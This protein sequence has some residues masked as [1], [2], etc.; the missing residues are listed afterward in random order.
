MI[1]IFALGQ[2]LKTDR[3]LHI[4][5]PFNSHT[6]QQLLIFQT[7]TWRWHFDKFAKD[8]PNYLWVQYMKKYTF[9]NDIL[10]PKINSYT[11]SI[12]LFF[13]WSYLQNF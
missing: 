2:K 10:F 4:V 7:S 8:F 1:N 5:T 12:Y 9:S 3:P 11:L 13:K 6:L